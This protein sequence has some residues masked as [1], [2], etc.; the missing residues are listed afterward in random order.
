MVYLRIYSESLEVEIRLPNSSGGTTICGPRVSSLGG[1]AYLVVTVDLRQ[2]VIQRKISNGLQSTSGA[3]CRSSCLL[4]S[5]TTLRGLEPALSSGG[6]Q[7][8]STAM[9]SPELL[10][11]KSL[12]RAPG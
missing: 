7:L 9:N 12:V 3:V 4:T 2:S 6:V 11:A 5:S 10:R 1:P 8:T